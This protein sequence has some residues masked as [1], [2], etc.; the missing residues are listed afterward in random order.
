MNFTSV[1]PENAW[2]INCVILEGPM[3]HPRTL[4]NTCRQDN[5]YSQI[6]F[7]ALTGKPGKSPG[8]ALTKINIYG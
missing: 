3:V 4:Q 1:T 7:G 6:F 5:N 8:G 2:G